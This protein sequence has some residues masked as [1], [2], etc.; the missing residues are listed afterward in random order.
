MTAPARE[1]DAAHDL[2]GMYVLTAQNLT[3]T[4]VLRQDTQ[5]ALSGTLSSTS[6]A[7]FQVD[8]REQDGMGVGTCVGNQ[9]GSYFEAHPEGERLLLA[10]IASEQK[11]AEPP[12]VSNGWCGRWR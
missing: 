5:G 7:Q 8:G 12:L 10:L 4:L 11:K 3:M 2:S 6:G 9:G 1:A